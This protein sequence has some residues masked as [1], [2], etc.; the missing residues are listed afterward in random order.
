MSLDEEQ[1]LLR[2]HPLGF[3]RKKAQ[4]APFASPSHNA[5]DKASI[6][7]KRVEFKTLF[8]TIFERRCSTM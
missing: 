2:A 5:E 7:C 8:Y 6:Q 1:T 3:C 4:P